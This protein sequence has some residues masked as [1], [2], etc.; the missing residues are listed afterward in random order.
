MP[1]LTIQRLS[2][3]TA[4]ASS[5]RAASKQDLIQHQGFKCVH[6]FE[7]RVIRDEPGGLCTYRARRLQ[8]I[9][10][11]KTMCGTNS[12]RDICYRQIWCDPEKIGIC[13]EQSVIL[14]GGL[15]VRLPIRMH[16]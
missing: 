10:S 2:K 3:M 1:G 4:R 9:G 16:E 5:E 13:G 12:C 15:L 11:S 7:D 6:S 14:I 8:R